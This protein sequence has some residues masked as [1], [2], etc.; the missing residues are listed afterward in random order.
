[1]SALDPVLESGLQIVRGIASGRNLLS[2]ASK[3]RRADAAA[4]VV[5]PRNHEEPEELLRPLQTAVRLRNLVV[6]LRAVGRLQ[7]LVVPAVI[8]DDLDASLDCRGVVGG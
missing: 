8:L 4:A 5:H 6:V 7:S 3:V 1:S 2:H